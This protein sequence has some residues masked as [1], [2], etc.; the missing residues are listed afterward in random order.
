MAVLDKK[1]LGIY[2]GITCGGTWLLGLVLLAAGWV[3]AE[4]S[5]MRS[6]AITLV[7]MLLPA[8]G[9][10]IASALTRDREAPRVRL[11]PLPV[12]AVVAFALFAPL[13]F[14]VIYGASVALGYGTVDWSV[15]YLRSLMPTPEET[16]APGTLP[17]SFFLLFGFLLSVVLGPTL[18]AAIALGTEIGWR[19]YLAQKLA[20][21]GR[22]GGAL[23]AG[24]LWAAC[25]VPLFFGAAWMAD[26]TTFFEA[27]SEAMRR[28]LAA[29]L[30]GMVL[31]E[32]YRRTHHIGLTAILAGC[33]YAQGFGMWIY[34]IRQQVPWAT[35]PFGLVG[36]AA[37]ALLVVAVFLSPPWRWFGLPDAAAASVEAEEN[38]ES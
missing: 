24:I 19:A 2:L 12:N 18:F 35:G 37:F 38:T 21:L 25:W 17:A 23:L 8:L 32:V 13:F 9:A 22:W 26:E 28:G 6:G 1:A 16:G 29:T 3:T 5:P 36:L 10:F 33:F 30:F 34:L 11:W 15:A 20:P 7:L 14:T 27:A 31:A 4:L